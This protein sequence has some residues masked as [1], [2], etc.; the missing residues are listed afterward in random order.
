ML[1]RSQ[2]ATRHPADRASGLARA[3]NAWT[4]SLLFLPQLRSCRKHSP[5]QCRSP[6]QPG[7][8]QR[9]RCSGLVARGGG[10]ESNSAQVRPVLTR[11]RRQPSQRPDGRRVAVGHPGVRHGQAAVRADPDSYLGIYQDSWSAPSDGAAGAT[12]GDRIR[13]PR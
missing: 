3:M 8:A 2:P 12:S 10:A 6:S 4:G 5:A 7:T 13:D 11:A 9:P 1:S